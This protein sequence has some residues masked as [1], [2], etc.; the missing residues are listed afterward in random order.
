MSSTE[1]TPEE[2]AELEER[3]A[4]K[5]AEPT[6]YDPDARLVEIMTMKIDPRTLLPGTVIVHKDGKQAILS[7]RKDDDSGWWLAKGQG[8]L[9]DRA[10]NSGDWS[11]LDGNGRYEPALRCVRCGHFLL[12]HD[13]LGHEKWHDEPRR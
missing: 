4:R 2:R 9:I 6:D 13:V 5:S 1:L 10:W 3:V 7:H 11:V 8:G 12:A